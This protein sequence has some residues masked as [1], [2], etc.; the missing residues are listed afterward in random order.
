MRRRIAIS[1]IALFVMAIPTVAAALSEWRL[2]G[3]VQTQVDF[4][5]GY[6]YEPRTSCFGG[7]QKIATYYEATTVYETQQQYGY[8]N[9]ST[10]QYEAYAY[11]SYSPARYFSTYDRVLVSVQWVSC[12]P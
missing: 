12:T 5:Y 10:G 6:S 3:D 4:Y 8:Y 2:I 11:F 9:Y 1:L 7:T